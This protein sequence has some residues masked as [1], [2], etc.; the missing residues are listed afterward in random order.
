MV[1]KPKQAQPAYL[2]AMVSFLGLSDKFSKPLSQLDAKASSYEEEDAFDVM[3]FQIEQWR[4]RATEKYNLG[5]PGAFRSS[6][7]ARVPSWA[8]LLNLRANAAH[9]MLLRPFFLARAPSA[10]AM[11]NMQPAV[12]LVSETVGILSRLDET[13]DI[14]RKQ[15]P[16]YNHLLNSIC[17]LLM[18]IVTY[19]E[20]DHANLAKGLPDRFADS[21][22]RSFKDAYSLATTYMDTSR[23]SCALWK[24]LEQMKEPLYQLGIVSYDFLCGDDQHSA[25]RA[26]TGNTTRVVGH[27][28]PP[29][30]FAQTSQEVDE[31]IMPVNTSPVQTIG[32]S[33]ADVHA[34]E[35]S[36]DYPGAMLCDWSLGGASTMLLD[37][38]F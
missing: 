30:P 38:A 23:A 18:L 17:A 21:L 24:R 25:A 15:H 4:K 35:D 3:S 7:L 6:N 26:G 9:A 2:K 5:Q 12:D 32:V 19:S 20:Q 8:I 13:T 34:H 22:G 29:Q 11:K 14:Y 27:V 33:Y 16:Y 31:S 36:I 10:A 37:A 1:I 28:H